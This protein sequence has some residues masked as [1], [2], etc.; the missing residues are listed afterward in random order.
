MYAQMLE[1]AGFTVNRK[2]NLGG[3]PI[4]QAAIVKGDIDLYPE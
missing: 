3:T 2:L 1:N 4:A